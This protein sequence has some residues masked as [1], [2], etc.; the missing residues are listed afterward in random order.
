MQNYKKLHKTASA[1]FE[2]KNDAFITVAPAQAGS[3]IQ[4]NLTSP[5]M[6]QFGKHIRNLIMQVIEEKGFSDIILDIKDQGAWDYT[7]KARTI[8]ALERGMQHE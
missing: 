3:G 2:Q 4:I 8:T 7:I 5:A 6:L 1:G